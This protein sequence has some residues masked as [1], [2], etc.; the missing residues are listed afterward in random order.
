MDW[1]QYVTI[2]MGGL[3]I[4]AVVKRA[5]TEPDEDAWMMAVVCGLMFIPFARVLKL[6]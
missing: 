5:F 2:V 4:I 1:V 3:M 6:I